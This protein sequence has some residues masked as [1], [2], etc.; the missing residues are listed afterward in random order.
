MEVI[1]AINNR[2][3]SE[4]A[5]IHNLYFPTYVDAG[6][7]FDVSYNA[8]NL[9][10]AT[11]LMFG[12][13]V[14]VDTQLE[15]PGSY[16]QEDVTAGGLHAESTQMAITQFFSGEVLIG[17]IT[18]PVCETYTDATECINAGCEWYDGACHSPAPP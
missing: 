11:Q 14:D 6:A 18:A 4:I 10:T 5:E 3:L 2:Q 12:Y 7:P 15:I 13:I 8:V 9:S 16:W 1:D 17:H